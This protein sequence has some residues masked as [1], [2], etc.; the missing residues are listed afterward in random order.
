MTK[1]RADLLKV[2]CNYKGHFT[3][4]DIMQFARR[5]G[6]LYSQTMLYRNIPLLIEAGIIRR[7][8]V[9]GNAGG[10]G[11]SYEHIWGHEHHDHL[12]CTACGKI[13]EFSFPAI[14]VLQDLVAET[15]G[16]ELTRHHLELMGRCAECRKQGETAEERTTG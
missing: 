3:P 2:I 12:V 4:E 15:H 5:Y 1:E 7:A 6:L 9:S 14:D 13:V 8:S 11:I 10:G 16:F